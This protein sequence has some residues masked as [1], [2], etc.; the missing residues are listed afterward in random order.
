MFL[1]RAAKTAYK[2]SRIIGFE[3]IVGGRSYRVYPGLHWINPIVDGYACESWWSDGLGL[4]E[5]CRSVSGPGGYP[6]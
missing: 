1:D 2:M 6:N 3:K 4:E 5:N